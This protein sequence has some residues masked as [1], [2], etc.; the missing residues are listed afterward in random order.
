MEN[1]MP[2]DFSVVIHNYLKDKILEAEETAKNA[3]DHLAAHARGKLEE[4]L[5]IRRYLKENIDLKNFI[6]Y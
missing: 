6:Y 4:L 1:F 3:D 5:W 2:N